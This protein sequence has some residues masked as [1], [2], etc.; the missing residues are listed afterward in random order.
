MKPA[1]YM[2]LLAM[3]DEPDMEALCHQQFRR[4]IRKNEM[5]FVFAQNGVEAIGRRLQND[6]N[7]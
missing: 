1:L 5:E 4:K 2:K 3:D 7:Y 6:R